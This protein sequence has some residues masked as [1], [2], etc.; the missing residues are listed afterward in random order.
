ML[1]ASKTAI[2]SLQIK[3][4][5]FPFIKKTSFFSPHSLIILFSEATDAFVIMK[6]GKMLLFY[7]AN[8]CLIMDTQ[9]NWTALH[10]KE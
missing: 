4:K 7:L 2:L 10:T 8:L 9:S 1:F 6:L 3:H 5:T